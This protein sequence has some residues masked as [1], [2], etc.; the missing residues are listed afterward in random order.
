MVREVIEGYKSNR[1]GVKVGV[2][3][4]VGSTNENTKTVQTTERVR[5]HGNINSK[6]NRL[7]RKGEE[8]SQLEF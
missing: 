5:L 6:R 8:N 4:P 1:T 7:R 2:E 3:K